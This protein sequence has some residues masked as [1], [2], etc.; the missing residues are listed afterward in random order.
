M[1][2]RNWFKKTEK[3]YSVKSIN[4]IDKA[5]AM[6]SILEMCVKYRVSEGALV[7]FYKV[8]EKLCD[9]FGL[10]S[11]ESELILDVMAHQEY[12]KEDYDENG[13]IEKIQCLPKG[14]E[15]YINGGFKPEIK[16]E[17]REIRLIRIGQYSAGI[18]GTYYLATFL[19]EYLG[20]LLEI[21]SFL[22]YNLCS[23]LK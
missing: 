17:L 11:W 15:K 20:T 16:S 4:P 22:F 1:N 12:I 9:D 8:E 5:K 3:I 13:D 6:D 18:V 10:H 19:K 21:L 2:I 7:D 23:L 14:I